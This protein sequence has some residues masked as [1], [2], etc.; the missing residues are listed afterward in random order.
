MEHIY[1]HHGLL[2]SGLVNTPQIHKCTDNVTLDK[3]YQEVLQQI[4]LNNF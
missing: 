2:P 1:S 3:M 4:Q